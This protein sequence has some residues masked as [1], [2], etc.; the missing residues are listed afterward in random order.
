MNEI[1][2]VQSDNDPNYIY[3]EGPSSSERPTKRFRADPMEV[4]SSSKTTDDLL[5]TLE[6]TK[7]EI[8][9][10]VK[11]QR[12]NDDDIHDNFAKYIASLFRTLP[13]AKVYAL[14]PKIIELITA[15]HINAMKDSDP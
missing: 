13:K 5:S 7:N 4:P 14:Q 8:L 1:L 9:D 6:K 11:N 3:K 10:A 15:E 12:S 2:I